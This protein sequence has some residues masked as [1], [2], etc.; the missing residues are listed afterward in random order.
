MLSWF[1]VNPITW[2]QE[3]PAEG[4]VAIFGSLFV[5]FVMLAIVAQ[6]KV[7]AAQKEGRVADKT[8]VNINVAS[9][10]IFAIIALTIMIWSCSRSRISCMTVGNYKIF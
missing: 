2:I 1:V 10:V 4:T 3:N 6:M 5:I 8:W 7:S 9:Y